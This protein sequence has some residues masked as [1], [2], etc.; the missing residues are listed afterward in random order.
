MR[1]G[2]LSIHLALLVLIPG[3]T[4][5]EDLSENEWYEIVKTRLEPD[6][7]EDLEDDRKKQSETF[8][9]LTKLKRNPNKYDS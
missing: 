9:D 7:I 3:S 6:E 5:I 8:V 2:V 1:Y 4:E